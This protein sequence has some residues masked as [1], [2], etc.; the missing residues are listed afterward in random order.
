VV[1]RVRPDSAV[2]DVRAEICALGN[3]FS[4]PQAAADWQT[5][6]PHG[7]LV[8]IAEDFDVNRQA[9]IVLGWTAT[10]V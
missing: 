5:H 9:M 8:P 7:T 10:R 4:S 1:S 3:F 2:A 6:Y